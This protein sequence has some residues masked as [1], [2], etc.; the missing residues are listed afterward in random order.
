MNFSSIS[1]FFTKLIENKKRLVIFGA[2]LIL[3]LGGIKFISNKGKAPVYQTV[4]ASKGTLV[5]SVSASGNVSQGNSINITSQASGVVKD[6][7]VKDGDTVSAG[8]KIADLTLDQTS[9]Q[10]L[11]AAQASLLSAQT[12]LDSANA[13]L[14]T[15]QN[16]EFTANQKFITDAVAR[17]LITTDPT[18]IE[19]DAAWLAAEA[20]YK[21]QQTVINQ[22][23]TALSSA[24]LS[25][26]QISPVITAP[27]GGKITNLTLT[28]GLPVGTSTS[29]STST[30]ST[31][32]TTILGTVTLQGPLQVSVD[33]SEVDVIKVFPGQKATLTLDAFP[34]KTFTGQVLNI[35]TNG[36]VTSGVTN[37]PTV[38]S[39]D[40]SVPNIYPNMA[41]NGSIITKVKNDVLLIPSSAIKT[42][43]GASTVDILKNGQSQTVDVTLGDS[44]DSQTEIT[45]GLNDG[46][47]VITGVS[48]QSSGSSG[49]PFSGGFRFGG[50]GGALRPGGLGGGGRGG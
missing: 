34:G 8:A 13:N 41:V 31:T 38:L 49:S 20:N 29:S 11:A 47:D 1:G 44:N 19:E 25:L 35:N 18:Y 2:I 28:P 40:T 43:N 26:S 24:S 9:Q 17:G 10:K 6:V 14:S 48:S 50:G 27:T 42:A 5:E 3:L 12:T 22:A 16:T 33:L 39:I 21:N 36:V 37:Y 46:D 23:Q 15:L 7:F 30:S 32:S 45:S 4:K